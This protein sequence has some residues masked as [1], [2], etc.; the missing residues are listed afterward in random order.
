MRVTADIPVGEVVA[1]YP[2][3]IPVFQLHDVVI[4]CTPERSVGDAAARFGADPVALLR[5]LEH[6]AGEDGSAETGA[7]GA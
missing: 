4:C 5:M 7:R 6:A 2:R 1:R 3:T